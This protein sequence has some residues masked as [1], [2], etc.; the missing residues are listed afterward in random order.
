M[1]ERPNEAYQEIL[2][3]D[4]LLTDA[5]IPHSIDRSGDG[6][7]IVYPSHGARNVVCSVIEYTGSF[8][9]RLDLLE[10]KGL[11]NPDERKFDLVV[12]FLT[13]EN[14]FGR[15]K[16]DWERRRKRVRHQEVEL[17]KGSV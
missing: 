16:R 3:L 7:H 4:K 10:I 8:G 9:A 14:V 15:I 2:R 13:A 12:G 11:L 1:S 6:W 17:P 5:Q